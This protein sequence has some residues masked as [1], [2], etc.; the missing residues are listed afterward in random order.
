MPSVRVLEASV[1][2]FTYSAIG[3]VPAATPTDLV[4]LRGAVGKIIKVRRVFVSGI[5][6][7]Q[8]QMT[9][10]LI[11]RTAANTGG[12]KTSPTPGKNDTNDT[13]AAAAALDLY[14]ANPSGLGAGVTLKSRRI[15]LNLAANQPDRI[16]WVLGRGGE[17]PIYLSGV[18]EALALNLG[19]GALP[20]GGV[21]DYEIEWTE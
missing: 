6:T 8:G 19:G 12:T 21:F 13:L 5:A 9:V 17:K 2:S 1:P 11:K 16:E 3:L 4:V 14:T 10:S 15:S 18:N 7:T 20:A